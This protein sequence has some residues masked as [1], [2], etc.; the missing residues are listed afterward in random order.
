MVFIMKLPLKKKKFK[1]KTKILAFSL[2]IL[3]YAFFGCGNRSYA[4]SM[5]ALTQAAEDRKSLPVES[6]EIE[7][8]PNGPLIGA[9]FYT[10]KIF[11]N[12]CIRPAPQ[13]YSPA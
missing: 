2:Y 13:K 1:H 12:S 11:T 4:A 5:D 10:A 7:N 8:W 9:E 6:N 3:T